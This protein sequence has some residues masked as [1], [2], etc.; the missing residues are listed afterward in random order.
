MDVQP[1]I[2]EEFYAWVAKDG[3]IQFA[4]MSTDYASCIGVAKLMFKA[5]ICESPHTLRL[6]GFEIKKIELTAV[7]KV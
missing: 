4:L 3:A 7:E 1:V 2:K 6:K 5:K